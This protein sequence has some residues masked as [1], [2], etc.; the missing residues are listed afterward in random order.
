MRVASE[1]FD[2]LFGAA[3]GWF[4][5]NDPFG[6]TYWSQVLLERLGITEQLELTMKFQFSFGVSALQGLQKEAA[7]QTRQ[8]TDTEEEVGPAGDPLVIRRQAAAGDDAVQV[9]MEQKVLAPGMEDGE[10]P[11]SRTQMFGIG[12]DGEQ[13]FSAGA[14]R[15]YLPRTSTLRALSL[16][17][18][19]A[20]R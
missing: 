5:I 18:T 2:D 13:G 8:N 14:E 19:A 11:H 6:L 1:V 9:G 7:E 4:G 15:R 17:R 20:T 16:F 3:K 12:G 10:E